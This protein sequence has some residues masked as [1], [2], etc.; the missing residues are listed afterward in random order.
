MASGCG[1]KQVYRFPHIAYPY[2][3][4]IY[5]FCSSIPTF[6][7]FLKRFYIYIYRRIRLL[8]ACTYRLSRQISM[9]ALRESSALP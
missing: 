1:C 9:Y 4:C 8:S 2:S 7:S 6:C 5:S 3:S